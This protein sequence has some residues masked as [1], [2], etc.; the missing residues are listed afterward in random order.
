[1]RSLSLSLSLSLSCQLKLEMQKQ[2]AKRIWANGPWKWPQ[3]VNSPQRMTQL[4]INGVDSVKV[5]WAPIHCASL[6]SQDNITK[7]DDPRHTITLRRYTTRADPLWWNC[8]ATKDIS[9]RVVRSW[10]VNR[11]RAA[12]KNALK[13]KGYDHN[14]YRLTGVG[15][16]REHKK[17]LVGSVQLM[18]L[19]K[20]IKTSWPQLEEQADRIVAE[21]E[22]HRAD[23]DTPRAGA[24]KGLRKYR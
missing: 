17:D 14:G 8:L 19:E 20:L 16:G 3:E 11:V 13:R 22:L 9:P 15:E 5:S 1:V 7:Q 21:V 6:N 24:W 12:F 18:T 10:A 2:A 23:F 4:S